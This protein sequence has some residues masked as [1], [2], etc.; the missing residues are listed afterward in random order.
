MT[1]TLEKAISSFVI[2]SI[3]F[4]DLKLTAIQILLIERSLT[5]TRSH[6]LKLG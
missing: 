5:A 4:A 1:I 2:S 6:I 3:V